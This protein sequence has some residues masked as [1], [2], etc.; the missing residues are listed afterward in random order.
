MIIQRCP[1]CFSADIDWYAGALTGM[2]HCKKCFY[3]GTIIL[4]EEHNPRAK[5]K[6]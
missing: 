5:K 1:K 4:E 3:T 2:Y 6:K